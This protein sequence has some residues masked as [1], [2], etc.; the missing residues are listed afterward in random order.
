A[1]S[2][3]KKAIV[4]LS[5]LFISFFLGLTLFYQV[6]RFGAFGAIPNEQTL[7]NIRNYVAS[8]VFSEDGK[9]LGKYYIQERT[10]APYEIISPNIINALI[11]TEDARFYEHDGVDRRSLFRVLIKT[12]LLQDES[13]GG[14]STISQQ[15]A[16]NL[17]P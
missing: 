16:K 11:A 6:V 14:G 12:L 9:L 13:A 2:F 10:H 3:P 7:G 17:Y 1:L 8:E 15:L 4:H 5:I